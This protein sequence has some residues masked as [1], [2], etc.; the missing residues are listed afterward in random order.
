MAL[1]VPLDLSARQFVIGATVLAT[2]FP[3][4]AA[5]TV[6]IKE[7]GIRDMAIAAGMML[8]LSTAAGTTLN[9]LLDRILPAAY[10]ALLLA[11]LAIILITFCGGSSD[12]REDSR[13]FNKSTRERGI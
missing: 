5:F 6:L 11:G 13:I 8:L 4:A 3:C 10:L 9:L 7:L 2:Y 1:L 12:R